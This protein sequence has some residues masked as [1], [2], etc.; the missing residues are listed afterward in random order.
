MS[1]EPILEYEAYGGT[2]KIFG[3]T[4]WDWPHIQWHAPGDPGDDAWTWQA[5]RLYPR[6]SDRWE[7]YRRNKSRTVD[8]QVM[9]GDFVGFTEMVTK[10][11]LLT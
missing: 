3:E 6:S 5:V 4:N 10:L 11:M 2:V 9:V 7:F 1:A 8:D